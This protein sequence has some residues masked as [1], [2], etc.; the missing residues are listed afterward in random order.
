MFD[1]SLVGRTNADG[2]RDGAENVNKF[3]ASDGEEVE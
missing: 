1:G 3:D 2:G